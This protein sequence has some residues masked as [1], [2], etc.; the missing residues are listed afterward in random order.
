MNSVFVYGLKSLGLSPGSRL[1]HQPLF[2]KGTRARGRTQTTRESG[3]NRAYP[4]RGHCVLF[5][6]K[7][8]L[9]SDSVSRHLH[10][11]VLKRTS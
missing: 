3:G 2:G 10:V 6:G 1:D 11:G 8:M 4:G 9:Y 5:L 7:K